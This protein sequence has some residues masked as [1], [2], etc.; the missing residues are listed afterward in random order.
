MKSGLLFGFFSLII[1]GQATECLASGTDNVGTLVFVRH[2]EKPASGLGQITCQ[3]LNR[4]LALPQRLAKFGTPDAIFAP[5]P[6]TKVS[7]PGGTYYYVRPLATIEPTAIRLGMP[8][9]THYGFTDIDSLESRLLDGDFDNSLVFISWEH[10]KAE[11][12]VRNILRDTNGSDANVPTWKDNDYDSIYI[13]SIATDASGTKHGTFRLE[14]EG[15]NGL[16]Q[17]CYQ[18]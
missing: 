6:T 16:S 8:V 1:A 17:T 11:N 18:P 3:G 5:N 10:V 14:A 13:L 12:V 9:N 2:G 15:L 4:A 7:D